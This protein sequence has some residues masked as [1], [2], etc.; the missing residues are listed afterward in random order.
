MKIFRNSLQRDLYACITAEGT[1]WETI[2]SY[3]KQNHVIKNW[4]QVRGELQELLDA[5]KVKRT[6]SI[7]VEVYQRIQ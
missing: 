6:A 3:I 4:L 7:H 2:V 5:N 1:H